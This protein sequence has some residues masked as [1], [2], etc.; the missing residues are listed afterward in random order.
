MGSVV[1]VAA[2]ALLIYGCAAYISTAQFGG[3]D[4][5]AMPPN[6]QSQLPAEYDDD[7]ST[8]LVDQMKL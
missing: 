2:I 1:G 6:V 8:A 3:D 4:D 7:A 5:A